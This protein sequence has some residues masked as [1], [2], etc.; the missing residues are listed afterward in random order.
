MTTLE[1]LKAAARS[2][3]YLEPIYAIK[4]IAVVEAAKAY[5]AEYRGHEAANLVKALEALK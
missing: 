2:G 4:L 3:F 5:T 1:K